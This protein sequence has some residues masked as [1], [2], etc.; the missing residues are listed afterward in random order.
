MPPTR[1]LRTLGVM[2]TPN[3]PRLRAP[4]AEPRPG[5]PHFR[6]RAAFVWGEVWRVLAGLAA[7]LSLLV[8]V[9][10]QLDVGERTL[11][12]EG[13]LVLDLLLGLVS[14]GLLLLR[15]RAPF[16]VAVVLNLFGFASATSAGTSSIANISLATS[17]R[18]W[19]VAI[20]GVVSTSA[21]VVYTRVIPYTPIEEITEMGALR[22]P[23]LWLDLLTGVVFYGIC[24]LIGSYIGVRRDLVRSLQARAETAEREQTTRVAQA[25]VAERTRIAREMHDVLAHRISLVAMHAGALAYRKDLPPDEVAR[26]SGILQASAHTALEDLRGVLGVLR[27]ADAVD[28]GTPPDESQAGPEPP[29]PT[30]ADLDSLLAETRDAGVAVR[31]SGLPKSASDLPEPVSRHAYR[32]IQEALTN[33]RKHAP[34]TPV[35]LE[36]DGAPGEGLSLE[37]AN[38]L[39][40]LHAGDRPPASGLGLVGLTERAK[41]SGGTVSCDS[42]DGR[43]VLTA[44]LPWAS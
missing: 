9:Q 18:W 31:F 1:D 16:T 12:S 24:V 38:P 30:L 14:S 33:A 44:W 22:V 8:L 40:R 43:F 34:G 13:L 20:T 29:Q 28:A 41:L 42:A 17:R 26:V 3:A 7:G 27:G 4:G 37:V 15:R 39:R 2:T 5:A 32:I 36:V 35:T 21:S 19:P 11:P 25:R 23:T 10:Y 6:S